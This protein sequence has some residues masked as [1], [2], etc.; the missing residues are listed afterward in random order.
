[1]D[2]LEMIGEV[3]ELSEY[4]LIAALKFMGSMMLLQAVKEGVCP[5]LFIYSIAAQRTGPSSLW[6][7]RGFMI[8]S[9][10]I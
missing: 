4:G 2:K 7:D 9:T 3:V 8:V 5:L 6:V 1:V 10:G